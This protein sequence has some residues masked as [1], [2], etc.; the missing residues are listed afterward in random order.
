MLDFIVVGVT[1]P[2]L[3]LAAMLVQ[4]GK[5]VL[6]LERQ[7]EAGGR[8]SSWQRE[9]Y[10]SLQGVPRIR[11]GEQGAF[12]RACS[13]IGLP[14]H[15]EPLNQAW[16]LDT[17]EKLKRITV[18]NPGAFTADYLSPWD[19]FSALRILYSLK[20]HHLEDLEEVSLEAWC[21]QNKI[22]PSLRR[23]FQAL[24]CEITHCTDLDRIPAG[25]TLRCFR[26]AYRARSYLAYPKKGWVDVLDRLQREVERNG[27]IRW[28]AR[29]ERIEVEHGHAAGVRVHGELIRA[30]CVVCAIPC[31]KMIRLLP[32]ESTTREYRQLCTRLE[33]SA[34]LIVDIA[35]RH[36]VFSKKGLWFF[37]D[38]PSYGTFL[39][40]LHHM[41]APPGKQLATFVCP[42]LPHE[43]RQPGFTQTLERKIERNLRTALPGTEI[44][45][46]WVRS[47]VVRVLDSVGIRVDQPRTE[48]PG[49]TVPGVA[50]LFLVGDST[51]AAGGCWEMEYESVLACYDRIFGE[52]S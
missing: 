21:L 5:R 13:R 47:H 49:Y 34:G 30:G 8:I 46:E 19:R 51:C 17:D 1:F 16:I 27:Q 40:N 32:R 10:L 44:H 37:L 14:L 12:C 9:G 48:R 38:P 22:R 28:D 50:R 6:L 11:Y 20:P 24:A 41:H 26:T 36:R 2:G 25:E 31:Q 52:E 7:R 4:R 35:L 42:C 45:V 33:P 15:L 43:A 29:V 3:L 23:T 18:G 39:S